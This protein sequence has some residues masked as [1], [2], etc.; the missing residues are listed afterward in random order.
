MW[1]IETASLEPWFKKN[2]R[3]WHDSGGK[4]INNPKIPVKFVR[5]VGKLIYS[6]GNRA[7][8]GGQEE[9]VRGRVGKKRKASK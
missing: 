5:E 6:S 4:D 1:R 3:K 9:P 2:E 8:A 7:D